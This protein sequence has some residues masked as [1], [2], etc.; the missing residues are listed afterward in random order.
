[1]N[2]HIPI[3]LCCGANTTSYPGKPY[4]FTK[5]HISKHL[6]KNMHVL[7][8]VRKGYCLPTSYQNVGVVPLIPTKKKKKKKKKNE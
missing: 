1:M 2:M 6:G 3:V 4:L 5:F 7:V 8:V